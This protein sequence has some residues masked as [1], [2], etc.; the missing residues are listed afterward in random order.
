VGEPLKRRFDIFLMPDL[1]NLYDPNFVAKYFDDF[2]ERE[3]TRLVNTPVDEIKLHIHSHYLEQYIGQ[4]SLVLDIGAGAGRFT[5]ILVNLGATV[6]V[7]DISHHQLEL[8]KRFANEFHFAHAVKDWLQLDICDMSV[9][10]DQTFDAVVCY[11]SPLGYVFEKKDEALRE[12][13]RVLKP[14]S[15]AFLSVSSLWGSIHEL[16]P[17]VLT[18][19]GEKNAEIIRTGD[20]HFDASEGLR[21]RC[22]L[23]RANEFRK[24]LEA[25]SVSILHLSA[26]NCIS[27][28]WG[29][30]LKPIRED[31]V[32]W[33]ELLKMELEACRQP[34]C[35][36]MGT[37]I[38]AVVEKNLDL[39][40][41][42]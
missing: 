40:G 12:V 13:L 32:R 35:L 24:F 18:V 34:G 2:G 3:W 31:L 27:T 21:H 37:H 19:S 5:Q 42:V 20:L 8:N 30:K 10:A 14:G 26:S 11:G 1:T 36:D 22:H 29:E 39:S 41:D 6:V 9:L 28:S 23:F 17:A 33:D 7:A 25:H 15:N 16:L 38:L 4:G